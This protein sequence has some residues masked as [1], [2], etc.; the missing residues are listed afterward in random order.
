LTV[1]IDLS[2]LEKD[3][4]AMSAEEFS[5]LR[6]ADLT[7]EAAEIYDRVAAIRTSAGNASTLE[8]APISSS[9]S[10]RDKMAD[11]AIRSCAAA[12]ALLRTR[13]PR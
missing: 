12:P 1:E 6:R 4:L 7:P 9:A 8:G 13:W 11:S 5:L 2:R 3:Y 10:H